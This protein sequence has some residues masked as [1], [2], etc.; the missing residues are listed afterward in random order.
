MIILGIETSTFAG[1]V[2]LLKDGTLLNE[3]SFSF[4]PKHNE[5]LI[6]SIKWLLSEAGVKKEDID[7]IAVSGGPGSFTSLRVGITTAKSLSFS[8]GTRLVSVSSLEILAANATAT[9]FIICPLINARKN[10]VYFACFKNHSGLERMTEDGFGH[11]A[12]IIS[13]MDKETIF[14]GDG[15]VEYRSFIEEKLGDKALFL[16][17]HLNIARASSCACLS[18]KYIKANKFEDSELLV[19]NYIRKSAAE[20]KQGLK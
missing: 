19:P 5:K 7:V 8:L 4:G 9:D 13:E 11:P 12:S 14:L 10:E 20:L 18:Q 16:P 3:Y 15:A 17:A 6:P 1:S 2:A